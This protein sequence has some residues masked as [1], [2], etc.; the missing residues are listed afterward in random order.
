MKMSLPLTAAAR[1]ALACA[2]PV[3]LCAA[4]PASVATL[5][6]SRLATPWWHQRFEEKQTELKRGRIDLL[7]LGDSITQD[8]ERDGPQPWADFAPIW[9]RFY[10]DRH[11]VNLG[12]R[13]DSTCHLLWRL[14]HGELDDIN[15]K[16]AILLIGANNFGRIHTDAEQTYQGIV[17]ILDT[18]HRRLP[19]TKVLLIGVLPSI[20]S[21]WVSRNTQLLNRRLAQLPAQEGTW[22]RYVDVSQIF[23]QHGRVDPSRF[24]DPLLSPP[25][26]PLHPVAAAQAELAAVIEPLV[27]AMIGDRLHR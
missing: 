2:L 7:W 20:R 3:L 11:A 8:W 1:F 6:V 21:H 16:A 5:P 10:G 12:F 18:L 15:P 13:G 14:K 27:A 19:T 24:L 17:V 26:P 25:D 23:E 22:L 9:Q 4:A